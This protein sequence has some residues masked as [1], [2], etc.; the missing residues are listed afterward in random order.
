L[1]SN[2]T[3]SGE[4]GGDLEWLEPGIMEDTFDSAA[5]ALTNVGDIT[6]LVQTSFGYH[7]IKLTD[8]KESVVQSFAEVQAELLIK[9]SNEQAQDKFFALQQDM[10]RVSFEYPDGLEDTAN[11]LG[12]LVQ[13]SAWLNRNGNAAP[14]DQVKVVEAAFSDMVLEDNMNSD[15]IEVNDDIALVLR[16]NTFQ[17]ANVKP[18]AE[19]QEQIK[20]LLVSQKATEKAQKTVDDLLV[21]L[22]AKTDITQQLTTLKADFETKTDVTRNSSEVEQ[23]ISRAAFVL[24]HPVEGAISASS[25][26]LSNGDLALV[27]VQKV[28][29]NAIA[30]ANPNL[31]KQQTSQL[32]QSAYQSYVASL[33]VDAKITRKAV[34][35]P[36][37]AY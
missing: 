25:V 10:A 12:A 11:E 26:T 9:V 17:E 3:F 16:L 33:K 4:N 36:T 13:T 8:Y 24:P 21:Q 2:D 23:N 1:L 32:A 27:E 6:P 5:L 29:Q 28:K 15:V 20:T 14:F 30:P 18:L 22:K 35:A 7:I 37:N 19:V 34:N 31:A